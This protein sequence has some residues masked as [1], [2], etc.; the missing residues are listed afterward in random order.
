[1][2]LG[3]QQTAARAAGVRDRRAV[4]A[5][6]LRGRRKAPLNIVLVVDRRCCGS[7]R[8]SGCC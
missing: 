2:T 1:M 5:K 4:A 3:R 6:I 8:R 7:C